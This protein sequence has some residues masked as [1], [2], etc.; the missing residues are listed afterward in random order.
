MKFE[1]GVGDDDDLIWIVMSLLQSQ[2]SQQWCEESDDR[3]P[4]PFE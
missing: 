3:L 4:E 2:P 1:D